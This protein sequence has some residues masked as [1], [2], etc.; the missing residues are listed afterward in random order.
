MKTL[1]LLTLL[2]PLA[3]MA[4]AQTTGMLKPGESFTN[5][6]EE[7]VFYLPRN[8]V[9]TLLSYKTKSELDSIRIDQY[10]NLTQVYQQRIF[11]SDSALRISAL[12]ATYWKEQLDKNDAELLETRKLN[13]QL[14]DEKDR[15]NQNRIVYFLSGVL[16]TSLVLYLTR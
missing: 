10:K 8:N 13:I 3:R 7:T 2:V 1:F 4:F 11:L 9:I 15:M 12:E 14:Q 6:S 5:E 16:G